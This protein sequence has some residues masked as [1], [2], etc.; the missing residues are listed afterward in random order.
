MSSRDVQ[1]LLTGMATTLT[2]T[3]LP[4]AGREISGTEKDRRGVSHC[5]HKQEGKESLLAFSIKNL[6]VG[7]ILILHLGDMQNLI[8]SNRPFL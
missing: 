7:Q 8:F 1:I 6:R 4:V 5:S 2:G 3:I